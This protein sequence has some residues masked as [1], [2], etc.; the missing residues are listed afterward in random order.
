MKETLNLIFDLE[1]LMKLSDEGVDIFTLSEA[2]FK[3]FDVLLKL[4]WAGLLRT[5]PDITLENARK[6]I[7]KL[8]FGEI[9]ESITMM[10]LTI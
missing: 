8:Q 6:L 10:A 1:A 7:G 4:C 2:D 9:I 3:K 5:N